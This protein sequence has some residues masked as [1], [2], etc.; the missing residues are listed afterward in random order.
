MNKEISLVKV[1]S[2]GQTGIDQSG[3]YAASYFG[4]ETGGW[5]PKG[6]KTQDGNCPELREKYGLKEHSSEKYPPRTELNVSQSD[7]TVRIAFDFQSAGE[8]ATLRFIKKHKKPYFDVKVNNLKYIEDK[9]PINEFCKWLIENK[10]KT[11]NVAGN[12]ERTAPG[13]NMWGTHFLMD[14]FNSLGIE[15]KNVTKN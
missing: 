15:V 9:P 12:S 10:I 4:L 14:V 11:L 6:F 8:L 13:I 7:G 1:I 2:G 3:L 5:I